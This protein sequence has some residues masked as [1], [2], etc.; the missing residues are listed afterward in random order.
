MK[1]QWFGH[2]RGAFTGAQESREGA[3]NMAHGGTL[4]LDEIGDIPLEVQRLLIDAVETRNFRPLGAHDLQHSD[5]QL[6][7]ATN[8]DIQ[9]MIANRELSQDFYFR[10][11]VF[12]Y[13]IPPLRERPED[14]E[15]ILDELLET[16]NY[17][18]LKL[19]ETSRMELLNQ[20]GNTFMPGNIR[21]IQNILSHLEVAAVHAGT[22]LTPQEIQRYFRQ[23]P[24][25][26]RDQEFDTLLRQ[27]LRLWPHTHLAQQ[28]RKWKEVLL[29]ES[30]RHLGRMEEY[31]KPGGFPH[32]TKL[33]RQLGMDDKTIRSKLEELGMLNTE[34]TP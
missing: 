1:S 24:E 7:C 10:F 31:Q 13:E 20:L 30:L 14:I 26:S 32:I 25:N 29:E 6:I 9:Q 15:V 28:G 2:V 8:R 12:S 34:T 21:S 23:N 5:F 19:S 11:S 33:A 16:G 4:F 18:R 3:L 17:Q 27:I 22:A